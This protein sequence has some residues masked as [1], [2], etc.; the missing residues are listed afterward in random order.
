MADENLNKQDV[1]LSQLKNIEFSTAWTPADSGSSKKDYLSD[2]P[3]AKRD[4]KGKRKPFKSS[5]PFKK[6]DKDAPR[7]FADGADGE[8][9]E[10]KAPFKGKKFQ[11]RGNF[12]KPFNFTME[13]NFYPEDEPFSTLS[14]LLRRL[15]RTYQLFEI[16]KIIL[17]KPERYVVVAK[18]LPDADGNVAPVYCA[19]PFNIPFDDEQSAKAYAVKE[20][21]AE[22]FDKVQVEVE[23]P[24]GNFLVVH[25]CGYSGELLGAPN[26]H[27]YADYVKEFHRERF[28]NIPYEK[29]L[30]RIT[31]SNDPEEIQKWV[32]NM[33]TA[34]VYKL[35]ETGETFD[36]FEKA[37]AYV[38]QKYT[39]TLVFAYDHV[40]ISGVNVS[41]IPAGRIRD[42][43][44]NQR[45]MQ[46][47]F[48]LN[49]AN[50]LRGRL[51]R[52]NFAIYKRGN[53]G[54]AFVSAVRRKFLFEGDKL[55]DLPQSVFEFILANPGI[56]AEEMPYKFLG[57]EFK[58]AETKEQ[59]LQAQVESKEAENAQC[60]ACN[61]AENTDA[62]K[63]QMQ[64]APEQPA[65]AVLADSDKTENK[66]SG[67]NAAKLAQIASELHWLVSEGYVVEYSDS[68][69]QAN[70]YLPKPKNKAE[71]ADEAAQ[72]LGEKDEP[73][74]SQSASL[75]EKPAADSA[76]EQKDESPA[77]N[78]K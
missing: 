20:K 27:K 40:R 60:A 78:E 7:K 25:K 28:P 53:K 67:E 38:S 6:F 26:W 64:Q 2:K 16:A 52:S 62:E 11:K 70:P 63:A 21:V 56:K 42:N 17:E 15:K 5:K 4:F 29:Y 36:T 68:S 32:D 45:E 30:A 74:P 23:A 72:Q 73:L 55:S 34:T 22:L 59:S 50:N 19:Q 71:N 9:R 39:D 1:D 77:S 46:L 48:S 57:I 65:E 66:V 43:I 69:L 61:S 18:N 14:D 35:K 10:F 24:K 31:S 58:A 37:A 13:V 51:R 76:A 49:T 3:F 8:K 75:Q 33:K 54:F 44:V 12:K 47:K 41:K